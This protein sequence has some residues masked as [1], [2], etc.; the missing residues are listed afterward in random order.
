MQ[1]ARCYPG[2][3]LVEFER[4]LLRLEVKLSLLQMQVA[5]GGPFDLKAL[6]ELNREIGL[7]LDL[8]NGF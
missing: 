8:P 1:P 7:L 4:N 6:Q 2:P 5:R 3:A